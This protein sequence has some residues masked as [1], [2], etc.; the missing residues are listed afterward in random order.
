MVKFSRK[1]NPRVKLLYILGGTAKTVARLLIMRCR[2]LP[3]H[4]LKQSP[5]RYAIRYDFE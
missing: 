5:P 2:N 1:P 3:D 4:P